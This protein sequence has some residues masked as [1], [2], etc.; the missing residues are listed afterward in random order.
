VADEI[1]SACGSRDAL[2][3]LDPARESAARLLENMAER[4]GAAPATRSAASGV[5]RAAE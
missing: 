4:I 3:E 2:S 1:I 5:Q